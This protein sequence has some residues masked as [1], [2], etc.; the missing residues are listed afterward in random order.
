M[1][2]PNHKN[3]ASDIISRKRG[4]ENLSQYVTA[5]KKALL[6][7]DENTRQLEEYIPDLKRVNHQTIIKSVDKN[8]IYKIKNTPQYES[9]F[10]IDTAQKWRGDQVMLEIGFRVEDKNGTALTEKSRNELCPVEFMYEYLIK[11]CEIRYDGN[12][13]IINNSPHLL[14]E[15]ES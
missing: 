7:K 9:R 12:V 10:K 1:A 14:Q 2:E 5:N 8:D 11:K 4:V 13:N 3:T 15:R 6:S